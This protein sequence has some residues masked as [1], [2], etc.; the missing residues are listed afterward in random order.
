[1][2]ETKR[3]RQVFRLMVIANILRKSDRGGVTV[4]ELTRLLWDAMKLPPEEKLT[5][6]TVRRDL[7]L[8]DEELQWIEKR[9]SRFFPSQAIMDGMQ[10]GVTY[11]EMMSVFLARNLL[12]IHTG[13]PVTKGLESLW[14]K[15]SP[16]LNPQHRS[17]FE[18]MQEAFITKGEVE[19]GKPNPEVV[20]H[21]CFAIERC[22][23]VKL[24]YQP[25][26]EGK[27]SDSVYDPYAIVYHCNKAYLIAD[28]HRR[29]EKKQENPVA[30]KVCRISGIALLN[31]PFVRPKELDVRKRLQGTIGIFV[32]GKKQAYKIKLNTF[33]ARLVGEDPW[34]RSQKIE[35]KSEDNYL[36]TLEVDNT[37]ELTPRV[38]GLGAS[39]EVLEPVVYR[40]EITEA[41]AKTRASYDRL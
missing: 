3:G 40:R 36:L 18:Q 27:P 1:M 12:K 30:L 6:R 34:H 33:A 24:R 41:L 26:M 11:E 21:L 9:G 15:F 16:L 8:L 13:T 29:R 22:C 19:E 28:S 2:D 17:L 23:S 14:K 37:Y 20:N 31:K 35:K 39:A 4:D 32:G 5:S 38:L 10:I 7:K 25:L